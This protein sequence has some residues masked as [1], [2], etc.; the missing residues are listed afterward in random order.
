MHWTERLSD[1]Q[2]W[3]E[4]HLTKI[5][6]L[7]KDYEIFM[8][9]KDTTS[10]AGRAGRAGRDGQLEYFSIETAHIVYCI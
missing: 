10:G 3:V 7:V 5:N 9:D 6:I 8:L 1:S 2:H 4:D